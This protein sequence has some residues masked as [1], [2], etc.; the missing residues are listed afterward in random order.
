MTKKREPYTEE[1][2]LEILRQIFSKNKK[3]KDKRLCESPVDIYVGKKL[4]KIRNSLGVSMDELGSLVGVTGQQ[5]Q[6]YEEG[7]NRISASR[8]YEF[9][10]ILQKPISDFFKDYEIDNNYYNFRGQ[11]E[12][13]LIEI[14]KIKN[15]EVVD[16]IKSFNRVKD[17]NLR[18]KIIELV[19]SIFPIQNNRTYD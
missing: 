6:K 11:E 5:I 13:E 17:H 4:R 18:Q 19:K 14:E 2:K 3:Y 9:S 16:L 15:Q 7:Y 10:R 12:E 1:E 8:L